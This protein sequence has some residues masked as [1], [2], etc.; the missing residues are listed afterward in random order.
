MAED[1]VSANVQSALIDAGLWLYHGFFVPGDYVSSIL[2]THA[3]RVGQILGLGAVGHGSV[4]SGIISGVVWLGAIAL[5]VAACKVVHRLDRA[6]TAYKPGRTVVLHTGTGRDHA[7]HR[8][9]R[10]DEPMWNNDGDTAVL[11][12]PGGRTADRCSYNGTEGGTADC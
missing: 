4:L 6:L 7:G 5:I 11:A 9:W 12:K 10:Q 3:P 1:A 8:Y 2:S